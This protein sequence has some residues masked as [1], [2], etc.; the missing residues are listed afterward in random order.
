MVLSDPFQGMGVRRNSAETQ[1]SGNALRFGPEIKNGRSSAKVGTPERPQKR[2]DP[3]GGELGPTVDNNKRCK[4][5]S[6][7][8]SYID[9]RAKKAGNVASK[10]GTAG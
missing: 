8:L 10:S 3:E 6:F 5:N 7:V 2:D 4:N 1:R 9:K